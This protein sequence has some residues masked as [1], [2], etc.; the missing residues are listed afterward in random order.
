MRCISIFFLI[1]C[2]V[3]MADIACLVGGTSAAALNAGWYD[4]DQTTAAAM[5]AGNGAVVKADTAVAYDHTAGTVER[6]F[7]KAGIGAG[8]EV[9]MYTYASGTNIT[10]GRFEVTTVA[11][12]DSYIA[13]ADITATDDNADSVINVG[14]AVPIVDAT[15]GLQEVLDHATGSAAANKVYIYVAGTGTLTDTLVLD[16]GAGTES[17]LKYIIGVDSSYAAHPVGT[18]SKLT[19]TTA[20]IVDAPLVQSSNIRFWRIENIH[21][22]RTGDTATAGE[23]CFEFLNTVMSTDNHFFNCKF[24]SGWIGINYAGSTKGTINSHVDTCEIVDCV[25]NAIDGINSGGRFVN[26]YIKGA[27]TIIVEMGGSL[28]QFT[29]NIISG[30]AIG[31]YLNANSRNFWIDNNSFYNQTSQCIGASDVRT[32][33]I[34]AF[35]NLFWVADIDVAEPIESTAGVFQV[36]YADYNFTNADAARSTMLTGSHSDNT[37]WSEADPTDLWTDAANDD[38]TVT[39]ASMIDGGRPTLSDEGATPA[40]GFSTPGAAQLAQTQAGGGGGGGGRTPGIGS[41]IGR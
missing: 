38:F 29:D 39:D 1:L 31:L 20:A 3:A 8:V 22:E 17:Y 5:D 35:N 16:A 19:A 23:D 34:S 37:L 36:Y 15:W 12:D 14:G 6:M 32:V 9:G 41:G 7:S 33:G 25:S 18:F 28:C 40:D 10:A 4:T 24:D 11:G 21:F 26:N 30:G 27:S 2:S 13:C